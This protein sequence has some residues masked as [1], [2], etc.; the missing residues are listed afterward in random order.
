MFL[1][2]FKASTKITRS[3]NAL[4]AKDCSDYTKF[5]HK[6]KFIFCSIGRRLDSLTSRLKE[7]IKKSH[8]RNGS[9]VLVAKVTCSIYIT[10]YL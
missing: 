1:T 9:T 8:I 10:F 6:I 2:H 5:K 7:K 4:T 3:D